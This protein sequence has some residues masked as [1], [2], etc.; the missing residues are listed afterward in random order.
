MIYLEG[1]MNFRVGIY[2]NRRA[3]RVIHLKEALNVR[4]MNG[5]CF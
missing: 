1:L 4:P 3:F 5:R 2:N